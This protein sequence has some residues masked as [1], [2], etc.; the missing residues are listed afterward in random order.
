MVTPKT[1]LRVCIQIEWLKLGDG[2]EEGIYDPKL[3]TVIQ[4]IQ[5]LSLDSQRRDMKTSSRIKE[6][7]KKSFP[8]Q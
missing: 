4:Y 3:M 2:K 7:I 8:H 6:S 5:S 1:S